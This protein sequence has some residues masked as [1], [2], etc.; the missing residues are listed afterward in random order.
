MKTIQELE[1]KLTFHWNREA[2]TCVLVSTSLWRK[3]NE[4][5]PPGVRDPQKLHIETFV[6]IPIKECCYL[7]G[8]NYIIQTKELEKQMRV[9]FV[10]GNLAIENP[11]VTREMVEEQ[12]N[13]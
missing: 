6:G 1:E 11:Y 2:I 12:D 13:G 9:G 7:E 3:L 10:Y 8:E 5:L 4:G